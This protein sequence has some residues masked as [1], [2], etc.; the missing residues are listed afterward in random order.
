LVVVEVYNASMREVMRCGYTHQH[1]QEQ[2]II[3]TAEC[4]NASCSAVQLW[5]ETRAHT[6]PIHPRAWLEG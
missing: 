3:Q 5:L 6:F 2:A 4:L 1:A